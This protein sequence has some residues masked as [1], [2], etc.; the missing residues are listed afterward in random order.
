MILFLDGIRYSLQAFELSSRR[1]AETLHHL[2]HLTKDREDLG[3]LISAAT[4]DAWSIVDS[5]HRLRELL[6]QLPGLKKNTPELQL[7]LR[8]TASIEDLRHYFQHFRTEIDSFVEKSMPLWGTISWST[9]NAETG[10]PETHTIVPGTFFHEA[11]AA[12]CTFDTEAG[13]FVGRVV[14]HAGP[15]RVDLADLETHVGAF[16]T[17]YL[18]WYTSTFTGVERHGSDVHM[19]FE[20][21][22]VPAEPTPDT[23]ESAT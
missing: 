17:W 7:F 20:I 12:S 6:Q 13:R 10:L 22:P 1:L 11:S 5:V 3:E 9:A 18:D 19:R 16:A 15:R 2:A 8:R 14:L 21:R 4:V 23:P